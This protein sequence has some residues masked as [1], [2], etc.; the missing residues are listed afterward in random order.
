[1]TIFDRHSPEGSDQVLVYAVGGETPSLEMKVDLDFKPVAIVMG[2][3]RGS[4]CLIG[5]DGKV[6]AHEVEDRMDDWH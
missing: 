3:R 5:R 4:F 6:V 1:M 2:P